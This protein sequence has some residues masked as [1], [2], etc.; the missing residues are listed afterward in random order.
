MIGESL[1]K[2]PAGLTDKGVEFFVKHQL[3][4][5][6]HDG[7]VLKYEEIPQFILDIVDAD[8][9]KQPDAM[10]ALT[11]WDLTSLQEMRK[12]YIFCRFGGFDAD[13]DISENGSVD[14]TEYFDCGRRG[15]C[16]H[17]GKL[18]SAIKVRNGYLTK[19]EIIVMKCIARGRTYEQCA[20]ELFISTNT[21]SSHIQN[22]K[23][24][25]GFESLAEISGFAH[26]KNFI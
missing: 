26:N 5:C 17:E 21:V 24:K 10:K 1:T 15:R 3:I 7:K 2:L 6:I 13:P 14:H 8:M 11:D 18:C 25:T 12:Q 23:E 16:K 9:V 19:Q 4:Y 20:D 22:I